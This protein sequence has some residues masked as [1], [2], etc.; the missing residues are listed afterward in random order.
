MEDS[1]SISPTGSQMEE[2]KRPHTPPTVV[3][4]EQDE[5]ST[6]WSKGAVTNTAYASDHT[7]KEY[8]QYLK[9]DVANEVVIT[10]DQFQ[11]WI[12][13]SLDKDLVDQI[14]DLIETSEFKK[15]MQAYEADVG[16]EQELYG[17]FVELAN[18]CLDELRFNKLQFCRNDDT[19]L[20][21]SDASRKPDVVNVFDAALNTQFRGSVD[22]L[23]ERGPW[24]APFHWGELKSFWEFKLEDETT[25]D[26]DVGKATKKSQSDKN[27]QSQDGKG[28]KSQSA[29]DG[30]SAAGGMEASKKT[31]T[32]KGQEPAGPTR[33]STRLVT[34]SKTSSSSYTPQQSDDRS[35]SGSK[36]RRSDDPSGP[37]AKRT[38]AQEDPQL[39]C[40]SYALELLSNGGLRSHVIAALVSRN[41]LELLYYDRSIVLK[42]KPLRFTKDARTFVAVLAGFAGLSLPQWGHP[43][44]LAAPKQLAKAPES[45]DLPFPNSYRDMYGGYTLELTG[46]KLTLQDVIFRAHGI[47]GRGPVVVRAKVESCPPSESLPVG[48]IVVVKWSWIAKTRTP[49]AHIIKTATDHA[50]AHNR[51]DMLNHLPHVYH[52]EELDHLT[53]ACQTFLSAHLKEA[54]IGYEDRVLRIIVLRE[55]Q[56]ITTITSPDVLAV[57]FKGIV[58]CHHWLH[59]APKIL[60]RDISVSNLMSQQIGGEVYGVM[61][62]FDLA[63]ILTAP[64]LSTSVQRTGTK[65]YMAM[66][67][68]VPEPPKHLYRHDLE[69]FLYVLVF[70]TCTITGSP[71]ANWKNLGMSVLGD[72][73]NN[74][75]TKTLFPPVKP[76]YE[77]PFELWIVA[78]RQIFRLGNQNRNE[79]DEAVVFARLKNGIVSEF[80]GETLGGA[81][82]FGTFENALA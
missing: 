60:H 33:K 21:G 7:Q 29:A 17:P 64:Q 5:G 40:A 14:E 75:L 26:T 73:K 58:E 42:S 81:V 82:T 16:R 13:A 47:I 32:K 15:L 62:D 54:G 65:P 52:D 11:K 67:L 27:K 56:P 18:H 30:G 70:L 31:R 78:L 43:K 37:P 20:R 72:Q 74:V 61:N 12:L 6:P 44:L 35:A 49:E 71:L 28:K 38:K 22:D 51:L 77:R 1:R 36:K 68:L 25:D 8:A 9:E 23:S 79:H 2:D 19:F 39:Q 55:L 63:I 59:D 41:S 4:T 46:W 66:D 80:D 34:S 50:I 57:A 69:S 53:P 45:T 76:G 3:S 24:Y 48:T 10:V